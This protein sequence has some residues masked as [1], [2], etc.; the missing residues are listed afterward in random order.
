RIA[1][2]AARKAER[3]PARGIHR[4]APHPRGGTLPVTSCADDGSPGTLREVIAGAGEGD[5]V[6][7]SG[8]DCGTITLTQGVIDL[9]VLGDHHVNDLSIVGPGSDV[10]TIDGNG[11]RVLAH[12]DF[13]VGLGTLAIGDLSIANGNYTHG[14]ASCIDSSGVVQLTRAVV[15]GC[16]ASGG[17]PLTFGGAVS[18]AYLEM[19][20]STISDSSSS[21]AG[22]NVAIGAGAYVSGDATLQNSTI[23][24]NVV[25]AETPGDGTYYLSAG[26]GLYVRGA[27]TLR[28]SVVAHNALYVPSFNYGWGG[29]I[30]VRADTEIESSAFHSNFATRGGGLY[31][32]VFSHYGDP[33]TTLTV[34]NSTFWYNFASMGAGLASARP[35]T[36]ASSTI[37]ENFGSFGAGG[38][39]IAAPATLTLQSSIVAR[40]R[41]GDYVGL[42]CDLLASGGVTGSNNLVIVAGETTILPPDTLI[43]DPL[44][45]TLGDH[46][47]PTPT[48]PFYEASPALDAGAN[49]AAFAFDQRGDG[50]L[51]E[52]GNAPDIG[53]IERQQ[54]E[55]EFL[56]RDAFDPVLGSVD[57]CPFSE[58]ED[59]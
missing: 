11:D 6:D 45:A 41:S 47:G 42:Y 46:G 43:A 49:P 17:G 31:K 2:R 14:L 57:F 34:G 10:L 40:N 25:I 35:A 7:L 37:S 53:A 16:E 36:I 54:G 28:Q 13:E 8:L 44:L 4:V 51:R 30:F 29:G 23:S 15:T 39:W 20:Y 18:A 12:G 21:A 52:V 26:G 22:D 48:V 5:V 38:A 50:F 59:S 1:Q 32:A 9:S 58:I 33:G 24:G 27:L 3:L 19:S 55:S 56:F